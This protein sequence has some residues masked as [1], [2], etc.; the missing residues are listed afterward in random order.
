MLLPFFWQPCPVDLV[1]CMGIPEIPDFFLA[2]P[3]EMNLKVINS[4]RF[5]Q[6]PLLLPRI[7]QEEGFLAISNLPET[8][9]LN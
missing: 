5:S 1:W 9:F 8:V 3:L 2:T 4:Y 6:L 7:R